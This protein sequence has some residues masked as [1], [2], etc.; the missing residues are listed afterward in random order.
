MSTISSLTR[1]EAVAIMAK[2]AL[3]CAC[4]AGDKLLESRDHLYKLRRM[5]VPMT[6][7]Y[8]H[9]LDAA[10]DEIIRLTRWFDALVAAHQPA[11]PG[12]PGDD[13]KTDQREAA[14]S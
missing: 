11:S 10:H 14:H 4:A 12:L 8:D 9:A 2:L 6:G 7:V 3:E 13:S 5:G 1:P